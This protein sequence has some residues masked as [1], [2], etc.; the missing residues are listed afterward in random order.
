MK[1]NRLKCNVKNVLLLLL[2]V[3][4]LFTNIL[5][6]SQNINLTYQ[7]QSSLDEITTLSK[8]NDELRLLIS[9]LRTPERIKNMI[10]NEMAF[11]QDNIYIINWYQNKT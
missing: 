1:K 2:L 9:Q 4:K 8:Q 3:V 10:P 11:I 6:V 7:V 5:F